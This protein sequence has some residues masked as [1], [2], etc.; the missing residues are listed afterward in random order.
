MPAHSKNKFKLVDADVLKIKGQLAASQPWV[1]DLLAGLVIDEM[2]QDLIDQIAGLHRHENLPEL[3]KI[4]EDFL[5]MVSKL[6]EDIHSHSNKAIL[7]NITEA[8]FNKIHEHDNAAVLSELSET[9]KDGSYELMY[10]GNLIVDDRNVSGFVT[11]YFI[12]NNLV[13]E[14]GDNE[15][16]TTLNYMGITT[17]LYRIG[18]LVNW[19]VDG[20]ASNTA[21]SPIPDGYRPVGNV[22]L[23]TGQSQGSTMKNIRIQPNGNMIAIDGAISGDSGFSGTWITNNA[24]PQS[25]GNMG[26]QSSS[27]ALE[28]EV[29]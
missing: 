6:H 1:L 29:S 4:T 24:F 17:M 26:I 23:F 25:S 21:V 2:P 7:N 12:T 22:R 19:T 20:T 27:E 14:D 16:T 8:V 13:G 15:V 11:N 18:N 9:V 10:K 5:A 3:N 28:E